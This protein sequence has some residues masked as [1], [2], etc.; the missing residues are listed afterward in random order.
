M[1]MFEASIAQMVQGSTDQMATID[2]MLKTDQGK[3]YATL[4]KACGRV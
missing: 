4:A 2:K 1:A 3:I